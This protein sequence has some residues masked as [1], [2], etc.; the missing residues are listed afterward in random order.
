MDNKII[1]PK[2]KNKENKKKLRELK[3]ILSANEYKILEDLS[4][5]Y[6]DIIEYK[7]F[8]GYTIIKD[9][10]GVIMIFGLINEEN[11]IDVMVFLADFVKK[12]RGEFIEAVFSPISSSTSYY[13]RS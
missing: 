13:E 4:L 11:R 5:S 3:Q 9:P 8:D 10:T 1:T 12:Y 2:I 7:V 6:S